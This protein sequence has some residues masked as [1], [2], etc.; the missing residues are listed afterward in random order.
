LTDS[1]KEHHGH[2]CDQPCVCRL[3]LS[4]YVTVLDNWPGNG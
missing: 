2:L 1:T 3:H 4:F